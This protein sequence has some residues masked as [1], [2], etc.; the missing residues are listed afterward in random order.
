[1]ATAE[2]VHGTAVRAQGQEAVASGYCPSVA[3]GEDPAELQTVDP[4]LRGDATHV[5]T[6]AVPNF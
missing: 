1:M 2:N 4:R 5:R 6:L 3:T